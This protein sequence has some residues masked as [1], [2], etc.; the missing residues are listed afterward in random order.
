[1]REGAG[2]VVG[3]GRERGRGVREGAGPVVGPG[4]ERGGGA[5]ERGRGV[6]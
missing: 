1:M 4:R 3:A 6:R 2:R 5:C